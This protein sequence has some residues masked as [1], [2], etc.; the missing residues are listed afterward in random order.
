ML[1][2]INDLL[3][4][5]K[6]EAGK[7]AMVIEAI[8]LRQIL[9]E[10]INLQTVHIQEKGLQLITTDWQEPILVQAD[11]AKLKQV[12]LNVIGNAVKFTDSGS[13]TIKT[14]IESTADYSDSKSAPRVVVTVKDTGVGID[15]TQQHKLFSPFVMVDGTT[16]RKVGGTGLGLAISRNL[17]ELMGGKITLYSAGSGM[18]TTVAITLPLLDISK[19]PTPLSSAH[20][21]HQLSVISYQ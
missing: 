7:L 16:T 18:G 5:A 2:I 8:D 19:L 14:Q 3:D 20:L 15:P 9:K 10:V 4:I 6:I 17:I 1:G 13:I 11:T 21:S 12:V